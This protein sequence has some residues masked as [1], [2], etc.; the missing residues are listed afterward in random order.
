MKHSLTPTMEN[1]LETIYNL[2]EEKEVIRVRDIAKSMEV[3]LP[4]VTSMLNALGQKGL[5]NHEKYEYVELTPEGLK[6][7]LEVARYHRIIFNFFRNVLKVD[8]KTADEDAC[9]V[10]HA[11]SPTTLK[12]L[13]EFME[14]IEVCPRTGPDWL[15]SFNQYCQGGSSKEERIKRMK[16]FI[17]E[18]SAKI[19]K[20]E[21]N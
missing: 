11:I 20:E 19:E 10:E 14:F 4:S 12:Q 6:I 16:D 3:K 5:V 17:E 15:K 21:E 8:S 13:A 7:A 18:Y 2:G 9:E 1:Y